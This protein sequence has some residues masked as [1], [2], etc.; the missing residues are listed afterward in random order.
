MSEEER[1]GV[2][3]SVSDG[4]TLVIEKL[5]YEMNIHISDLTPMICYIFDDDP[6]NIQQI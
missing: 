4:H 1:E 2:S 3:E 5:K 6:V